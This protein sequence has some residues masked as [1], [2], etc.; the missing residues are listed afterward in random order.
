MMI[1]E[2]FNNRFMIITLYK[3]Y[4]FALSTSIHSY[5]FKEDRILAGTD[6]K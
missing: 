4:D 3:R 1:E 5:E 2:K 6:K